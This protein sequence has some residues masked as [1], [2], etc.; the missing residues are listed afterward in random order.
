MSKFWRDLTESGDFVTL[1]MLGFRVKCVICGYESSG[2]W[3]F[4]KKRIK[5]TFIILEKI[6]ELPMDYPPYAVYCDGV[7][8]NEILEIEATWMPPDG[9]KYVTIVCK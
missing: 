8:I 4:G 1:D 3:V 9:Q 7:K 5:V 6:E 2:W